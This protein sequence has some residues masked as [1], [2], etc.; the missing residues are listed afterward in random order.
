[1]RHLPLFAL[2]LVACGGED[3]SAADPV[4]PGTTPEQNQTPV[5]PPRS[6]VATGGIWTVQLTPVDAQT[7][8]NCGGASRDS[9]SL[10]GNPI[11]TAMSEEDCNLSRAVADDGCSVLCRKTSARP[12]MEVE[13]LVSFESTT[14]LSGYAVMTGN[15]VRCEYDVA[16]SKS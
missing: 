1:M 14:A 6:C 11:E 3:P 12:G 16:Y 5:E 7:A 15:G 8:A 2:L 9:Q 4:T 10:S 13:I